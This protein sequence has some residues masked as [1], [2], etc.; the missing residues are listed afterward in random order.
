MSRRTTVSRSNARTSRLITA[1]FG[2]GIAGAALLA[3]DAG[4]VSIQGGDC[5]LDIG[6]FVIAYFTAASCSGTQ[7][8]SGVAMAGKGLGCAG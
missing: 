8:A 1:L 6:G 4:A 5:E 2:C 7:L 3:A